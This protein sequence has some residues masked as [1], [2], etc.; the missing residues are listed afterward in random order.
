MASPLPMPVVRVASRSS[1]ES[2][3]CLASPISPL[4][5]SKLTSS[6]M[7]SVLVLA[8]RGILMFEGL[9]SSVRR[10]IDS[11]ARALPGYSLKSKQVANA[12][13]AGA[14]CLLNRFDRQRVDS[15]QKI[16]RIFSFTDHGDDDRH[17]SS[18]KFGSAQRQRAAGTNARI[19]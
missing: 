15:D 10:I 12:N 1:T 17:A 18:G 14:G 6:V 8:A 11:S 9:R 13:S 16:R 19:V 4:A 5:D 3:T 7:A 2:S